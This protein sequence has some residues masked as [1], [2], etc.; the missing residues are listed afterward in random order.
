MENKQVENINFMDDAV[1][2]RVMRNPFVTQ[3]FPYQLQQQPSS[4][5]MQLPIP[6]EPPS[7]QS[8]TYQQMLPGR[9]WQTPTGLEPLNY[10]KQG[11]HGD[12]LDTGDIVAIL[13]TSSSRRDTEEAGISLEASSDMNMTSFDMNSFQITELTGDSM[14]DTSEL[15]QR[16]GCVSP[17]SSATAEEP[18]KTHFTMD[19]TADLATGALAVSAISALVDVA[20][21]QF[22]KPS[23][24]KLK[25]EQIAKNRKVKC[26][27]PDC[28]NQ[29]RVSQYYGDFCNRHV[30][31]APCGFPGCRDK[32]MERA[33]MCVEL[34]KEALHETLNL[35]TQNV[36]VCQ[37]LGCFKN[38]Q[39]RGYCR[40]HEKLMMATGHLPP[41]INK[42][43]LNSAYTMCS[44]P[45]CTKHSQR[46]HLCRTHG[47]LLIVQ[48][49]EL[50]DRPGATESY[51][52][53]LSKMQKD[54]RRCT[55]E[56]C[57]K[58]S[59]RDRLCTTHLSEKHNQQTKGSI[60]GSTLALASKEKNEPSQQENIRGSNARAIERPRGNKL[61]CE[62]LL[63]AGGVCAKHTNKTQNLTSSQGRYDSIS[64]DSAAATLMAGDDNEEAQALSAEGN[65]P[66]IFSPWMGAASISCTNPICDRKGYGG[67]EYCDPCQNLFSRVVVPMHESSVG[68]WGFPSKIVCSDVIQPEENLSL[69]RV[70]NCGQI[71]I[72]GGLCPSHF[73]AFETGSLSVD[74]VKLTSQTQKT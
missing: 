13:D 32:A 66:Q 55:H 64:S 28:P 4:N 68:S 12:S 70:A 16:Y 27:F 25:V 61:G 10:G 33:A 56:N 47:N 71:S 40:G 45:E 35:R 74:Q 26:K 42:R 11:R 2:R 53:I 3:T 51:D 24:P 19:P 62:N 7:S 17:E 15:Y 8:Y 6:M 1:P 23:N 9:Y 34:G 22:S 21:T 30:I 18:M 72:Y 43:R 73:Q 48:A 46:H 54:I 59:Q 57:M 20:Y 14:K 49:H 5:F 41:H 31:V 67:Q 50:A 39:G 63:Y 37:T 36:P 29:A 69:C 58:N 60:P 38:D 44:Y 65:Q 52:E